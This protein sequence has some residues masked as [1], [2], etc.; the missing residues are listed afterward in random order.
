MADTGLQFTDRNL[1]PGIGS[2]W[3]GLCDAPP[4]AWPEAPMM[5]SRRVQLDHAVYR[6]VL[7][8]V[9]H[10]QV[11][12]AKAPLVSIEAFAR[13]VLARDVP[14]A[15]AYAERV[16][17]AGMTPD[18]LY[19]ELLA[20]TARHL[21][22]LW[23]EDLLDFTQ[24]TIGLGHL[25]RVLRDLSPA[26]QATSLP[27]HTGAQ[28]HRALLVAAPGE[29]HTFGLSMVTEFFRRA[30][31]IV[32]SGAPAAG[33]ELTMIVRDNWFAMAGFSLAYEGRLD[34]LRMGIGKVRRASQNP[35]IA[36]MVGGPVFIAHPEYVAQVGADMM[37]VDGRLAVVQAQRLVARPKSVD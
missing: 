16:G 30:G 37:A 26:F 4:A 14:L 31:W 10:G 8:R 20:P 19:L 27:L 5:R 34:A 15:L 17:A 11:G 25:Q 29:Q 1:P 23:S 24:V 33:A 3:T 28:D 2:P 6:D 35:A 12:A 21:G 13:L 36:I 9:M 7:P 18:A 32:W 22:E